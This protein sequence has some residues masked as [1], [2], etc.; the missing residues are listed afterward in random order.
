MAR[1]SGSGRVKTYMKM[2][3][4]PTPANLDGGKQVSIRRQ[5]GGVITLQRKGYRTLTFRTP[6][7]QAMFTLALETARKAQGK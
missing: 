4:G 2:Q 6:Q 3:S 7:E 1:Q 5:E